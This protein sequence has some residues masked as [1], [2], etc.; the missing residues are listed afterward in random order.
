MMQAVIS[1][2]FL[3]SPAFKENDALRKAIKDI[4]KINKMVRHDHK[5]DILTED[6]AIQKLID[7]DL[8]PSEPIF[9]ENLIKNGLS[10]E[11]SSHDIVTMIHS[12][13]ERSEKISEYTDIFDVDYKT[14]ETTP[15][16]D[17]ENLKVN[18]DGFI[19]GLVFISV[20][21]DILGL[22]LYL[23][24][25]Q[26]H[27][28]SEVNLKS[29]QIIYYRENCETINLYNKNI[30]LLPSINNFLLTIGSEIIW[31]T[32]S[33]NNSLYLSIYTRILELQIEV[34]D[35]SQEFDFESFSIGDNFISSLE[36]HQCA[37]G[38]RFGTA[39]FETMARVIFG[40]PKY[41][42]KPFRENISANSPIRT[43]GTDKA[44][45]THVTKGAEGI[46]LMLWQ[47][48]NGTYELANV[49]NKFQLIIYE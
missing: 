8:Y 27:S 19:H 2:E 35:D 12:I 24:S 18:L 3:I 39:C 1:S 7:V 26:Y 28:N 41:E 42:V 31:N 29:D 22:N 9:K 47:S 15:P 36:Q 30:S 17:E 21:N 44:Y 48:Q 37:P 43:R 20:L 14:V 45:R 38:Q 34:G 49:G 4:I 40:M 25:N 46:R 16:I 32:V 13:I 33:N 23:I 10:D 6:D 11:F 5:L